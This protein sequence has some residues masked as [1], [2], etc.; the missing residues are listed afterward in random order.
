M[1]LNYPNKGWILQGTLDG[2]PRVGLHM[3]TMDGRPVMAQTHRWTG[4]GVG[5]LGGPGP[6][7]PDRDRARGG[8]LG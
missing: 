1:V 2:L 4:T 6:G 5:C 7:E 8:A 3:Q